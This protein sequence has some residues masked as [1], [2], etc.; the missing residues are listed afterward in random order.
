MRPHNVNTW[1]LK[2]HAQACWVQLPAFLVWLEVCPDRFNTLF[3]IVM[4]HFFAFQ[5]GKWDDTWT[6]QAVLHLILSLLHILVSGFERLGT[7]SRINGQW[8]HRADETFPFSRAEGD[9]TLTTSQISAFKMTKDRCLNLNQ[10]IYLS[11]SAIMLL[12]SFSCSNK[13]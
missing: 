10:S 11:G 7:G 12:V 5:R 13:S 9:C 8:D 3:F 4:N 1:H 2:P 6:Q